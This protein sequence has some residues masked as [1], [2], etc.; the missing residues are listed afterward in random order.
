MISHCNNNIKLL[1]INTKNHFIIPTRKKQNI[2]R[3]TFAFVI[4][5]YTCCYCR[6]FFHKNDG[7]RNGNSCEK[8]HRHNAWLWNRH[9]KTQFSFGVEERCGV[10]RIK[11]FSTKKQQHQHCNHFHFENDTLLC[12]RRAQATSIKT[13]Q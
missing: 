1:E 3:K 10:H 6:L 8:I 9:G 4:A 5:V 7:N 12:A 2:M 13:S 11:C